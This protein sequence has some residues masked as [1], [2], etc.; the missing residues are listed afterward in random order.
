MVHDPRAAR[1]CRPPTTPPTRWRSRSAS[2]TANGPAS[3]ERRAPRPGRD[4]PDR[5]PRERLRA[6]R[7]RGARPGARARAA[8]SGSEARP[9]IASI[10]GVV[11]RD[12][13]RFARP[14]GRRDR[15]PRLRRRPTSSPARRARE[16][17]QAPHP[18]PRPRGPPGA[19]R[20]PDGRRAG[21]LRAAPDGDRGRAQGRPR[22][23]RQPAGRRP[24]ARDPRAGRGAPREHPGV[25]KKLA[26]RIILELKEKVAAAGV[27]ARVGGRRRRARATGE[28][29]AALQA[30]GYTL[31][32]A[33]EAARAAL[34]GPGAA[35]TRLEE[36]VKAALRTLVH[37]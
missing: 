20:L 23:R 17:A 11:G 3:G 31:G 8:G 16:R 4:R 34:A 14:R 5:T 36:R 22:D 6:G 2:P 10:E 7:S 24:P 30:L 28:V 21:L 26:E 27:A 25:G 18:P 12:R 1:R 33:R 15:L 32:E 13:R 35:E 29:V 9:V 37:D 19:V